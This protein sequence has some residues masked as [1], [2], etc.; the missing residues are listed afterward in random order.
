M[1]SYVGVINATQDFLF[2]LSLYL[3]RKEII[4]CRHPTQK[5]RMIDLIPKFG[6]LDPGVSVEIDIIRY[7]AN[8]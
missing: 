2:L 1:K 5:S 7:M 6:Y 4:L 3:K 8:Y